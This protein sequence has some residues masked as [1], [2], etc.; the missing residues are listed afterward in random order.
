MVVRETPVKLLARKSRPRRQ[1]LLCSCKFWA[2][3]IGAHLESSRSRR[4]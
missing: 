2:T 3:R 4:A 1:P